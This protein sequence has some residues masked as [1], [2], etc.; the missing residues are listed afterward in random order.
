M[1]REGDLACSAQA[2][3]LGQRDATMKMLSKIGEYVAM[4]I[5]FPV[6]VACFLASLC[7]KCSAGPDQLNTSEGVTAC[8]ALAS[9][10]GVEGSF[11][12]AQRCSPWLS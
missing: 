2:D 9:V 7:V 8:I 10:G 11:F 3:S 5:G 12:T 4:A 1:S 6:L